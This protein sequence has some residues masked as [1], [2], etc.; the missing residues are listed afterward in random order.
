MSRSRDEL[1]REIGRRPRVSWWIGVIMAIGFAA[2]VL[3]AI[4]TERWLG[5]LGKRFVEGRPAPYTLRV[6]PF[7]GYEVENAHVGG[8][9]VPAGIVVSRGAIVSDKDA[10]NAARVEAATPRGP[11]PYLTLFFLVLVF[12]AIFAHHT[13]RS[14][15][16][17]LL[18]VQLVTLGLIAL[19]AW[20]VKIAMLASSMSILVVPVALFAMVPTIALDRVVG[21]ATGVLAAL[22]IALVGPFDVGLSILMLVQVSVAGLVISTSR[23]VTRRSTSYRIRCDRCGSPRRSDRRS[24]RCSRFRC[25]R[26]TSGSSARSRPES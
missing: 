19:V 23:R 20:V 26:S 3:P 15:L 18:R 13:R 5:S 8:G 6:P 21:L 22:V 17:R 12:A 1:A 14:N 24:R 9:G 4:T 7:N 16:G 25:C 2:L 10:E 11:L